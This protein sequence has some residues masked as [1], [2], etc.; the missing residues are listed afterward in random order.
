MLMRKGTVLLNSL[1]AHAYLLVVVL[2][3]VKVIHV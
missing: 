2:Q 1:I 3:Y